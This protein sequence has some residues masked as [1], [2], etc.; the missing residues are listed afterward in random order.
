M[1]QGRHRPVSNIPNITGAPW[2]EP[3]PE[4]GLTVSVAYG[5]IDA[6]VCSNCHP[7]WRKQCPFN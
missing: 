1:G 3:E 7:H 5:P 6:P 2:G 4:N